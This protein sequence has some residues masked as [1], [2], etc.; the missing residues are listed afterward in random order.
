MAKAAGFQDLQTEHGG[1]KKEK[2]GFSM[3]LYLTRG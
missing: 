2:E 3:I 1:G